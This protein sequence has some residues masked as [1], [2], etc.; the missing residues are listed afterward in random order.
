MPQS[1]PKIILCSC[2]DT[3]PLDVSRIA[4]GC[5]GSQITTARHLCRT[6]IATFKTLAADG[7]LTLACT[8]E[9]STF[10]DTAEENDLAADLSFVN[11][12][13]FAGWSSQ[14]KNA[15]PKIAALLA[16]ATIEQG[17]ATAVTFQSEGVTL[18]LGVDQTAIDAALQLKDT[19]DITVIITGDAA[20]SPPRAN[21]IPIRFGRV[22]KATGHMGAFEVTIDG[23]AEPLASSRAKLV[24][25]PAR[26][27]AVSKPDVIIDLTGNQ[28]LFT[29]HDLR[30]G[31]L[32]ASPQSPADVQRL[33]FKAIDLKGTFDKPRYIAF[34]ENLCAHSRSRIT[35]CTRCLDVCPAGAITPAGRVVAID[36]HICGGCGA[37]AAV[38]PTGAASY[39]VPQADALMQ[40]VRA[41]LMAYARVDSTTPP[42]IAFHDSGHGEELI[43]AASRF[44]DGLPAHVIPIAVN[45]T[46]QI[47]L[48]QCAAAL[49]Y[50]ATRV[51]VIT[52]ARPKHDTASLSQTLA[53]ASLLAA[54]LGYGDATCSTI[55]TDDPDVLTTAFAPAPLA[56]PTQRPAT[57]LPLGTKRDVLKLALREL[58]RAAPAP[59]DIVPMPKLAAFGAVHV[60]ADGCTLCL[61][62]V[63]A[64]PPHALTAN[65]DAPQLRFDESLCVQCGLCAATCPEKVITLE[66]RL[67]FAA[68]EAGPV[69]LKQEEPFCCTRCAK[70]FGV[71]S[72]VERVLA[73]LE[74]QH[75]MF[76][77][78]NA[79]RLDLIKMCDTCR[80]EVA[81]SEKMDP[82]AGPTRANPKTT[83]DYLRERELA[84]LA[85]IKSG[86]A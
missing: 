72:T 48:E 4:K 70:P 61:A 44:G 15:A 51:R 84:M 63:S 71:K 29:G 77:G 85:K 36:P 16:A 30:E 22:R 11:I 41:A 50:G 10:I 68:F 49:A 1:P 18:I 13:E 26:N 74:G 28:P 46:T 12:R 59:I 55:A 14:G 76:T 54:A 67:N 31:Y 45:E 80:I 53:T 9:A 34:D 56:T 42:V 86:E 69:T 37:C 82:Y 79:S 75:W 64:C 5:P 78:T 58:H 52:R 25:G 19:L 3:I 65:D 81:T 21:T 66:P 83:E 39:D 38:C 6:E 8:Q 43:F 24:A 32:R 60:K 35:G 73:K 40:R 57:F 17:P 20:I 62:C 27:G 7:A 23:Y 47:G 2:E 33:L